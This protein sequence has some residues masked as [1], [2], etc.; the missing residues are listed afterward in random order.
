MDQFPPEAFLPLDKEEQDL[1]MSLESDGWQ[2]VA[3]IEE[4]K[5]KAVTAARNTIKKNKQIKQRLTQKAKES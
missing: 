5:A 3:N 1:M 4:E 2:P